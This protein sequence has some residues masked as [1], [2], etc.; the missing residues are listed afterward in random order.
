MG[1]PFTEGAHLLT[2]SI[3]HQLQ[4]IISGREDDSLVS[5]CCCRMVCPFQRDSS[6]LAYG[7][8]TRR[9]QR[10]G[11]GEKEIKLEFK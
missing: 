1:F 2:P 4:F 5:Q 9:V 6:L 7:T 11:R 8:L 10:K 3:L